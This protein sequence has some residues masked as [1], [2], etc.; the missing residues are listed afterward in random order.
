M[1]NF[2]NMLDNYD[3]RKVNRFENEDM[4]IDTCGVTDGDNPYETAIAHF[5]YDDKNWIIVESY[6][7]IDEAKKG[8]E[9]WVKLMIENPPEYLR[10]CCNSA[11]SKF[12]ER[13]G[14]ETILIFY[15]Q[16]KKE[17]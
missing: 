13:F 5:L 6:E 3:D 11:I 7:T 9:K 8:H 12:V 10:D 15:R 16:D 17:E 14:D 4:I 1:F 2:L